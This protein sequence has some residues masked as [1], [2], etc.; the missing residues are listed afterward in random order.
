MF[1]LARGLADFHYA[2]TVDGQI[3]VAPRFHGFATVS[4]RTLT[5]HGYRITVDGRA[6]AHDLMPELLGW[7]AGALSR[8]SAHELTLIPSAQYSTPGVGVVGVQVLFSVGT[9]GTVVIAAGPE[10]LLI[11]LSG[12]AVPRETPFALRRALDEARLQRDAKQADVDARAVTLD[13][14]HAGTA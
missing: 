3:T 8:A 5:L 4:W 7:T 9:D 10:G 14:V 13:R 11:F 2:L 12:A 6:L 1:I